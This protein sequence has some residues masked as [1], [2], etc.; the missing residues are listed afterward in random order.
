MSYLPADPS[1]PRGT[2]AVD[3]SATFA[4]R[5]SSFGDELTAIL[6]LAGAA[7][8]ITFSGGFPAPEVFPTDALR[9]LLPRLAGADAA[10][11]LQY[12]PTEGLPAARAAVSAQLERSQGVG[13]DPADVLITSGGIEGL[14]LLARTLLDPG[15]RVLVEAPTYLGAITAFTGFEA[16][17]DGVEM[18]EQ[19]LRLDALEAALGHGR[20]PKLLYVIPDHQNPTGRTLPPERRR[21]LV[22]LCRRY[23]VLIVEDV[24]YREL[25]FDGHALPSLWSLAPDGVLQLGTFS[26]IFMPGVRL[27]WAVGPDAV[28]SA[29]TSAKQN[30]DQCAG[31]LGQM[32]MAEFLDG[33]HLTANLVKARAL[34]RARAEA[35]TDALER[36]MP[37][38]VTWLRPRGGFFVWLTAPAHID[39][40]ALVAPATQLGV[41]YVPGRP[42]YTVERGGNELRLAFSGVE[43]VA[44][45][46][47]IRRLAELLSPGRTSA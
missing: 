21:G 4:R 39:T 40:R 25:G 20:P 33:G 35:M 36:Y 3:W 14:Q 23:G 30:S 15:D 46:E 38:G 37:D 7:D 1:R 47:G 9:Q 13:V 43:P 27:G 6:S 17:V 29:M 42:F 10:V 28:V 5:T 34:Y 45:D 11:A 32:L 8:V 31:A 16:T 19:G 24:A 44:I 18:D 26:K 22:E 12:S 41:A 2:D